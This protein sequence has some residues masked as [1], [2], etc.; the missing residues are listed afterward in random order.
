MYKTFFHFQHTALGLLW[1]WGLASVA[2]GSLALFSRNRALR[3]VGVQWLAW[4]AIEAALARAGQR[5]AM[6][7][8]HAGAEDE[9]RHARRFRAVLLAGAALDFVY[10]AAGLMLF[11]Q[12]AG[13]SQRV[14]AGLGVLIQGLFLLVYDSLLALRTGEWAR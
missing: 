8:I 4:G 7:H 14:G 9:A 11:R 13:R 10:V 6:R 5:A 12:A 2:L 3:Q 1:R